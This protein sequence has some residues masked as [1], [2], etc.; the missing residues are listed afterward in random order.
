MEH[1]GA[2]RPQSTA[3]TPPVMLSPK[4]MNLVAASVARPHDIDGK[5]AGGRPLLGI[6]GRAVTLLVPTGRVVPLA[7]VQDVVTGAAPPVTAGAG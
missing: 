1:C 2:F 5:R 3:S 4:A 7:G 6:A